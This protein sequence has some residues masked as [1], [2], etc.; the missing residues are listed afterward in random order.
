MKMRFSK[1]DLIPIVAVAA[2]AVALF[3][4]FLPSDAPAARV[5][6]YQKGNLLTTLPLDKDTTYTVTGAYTNIV[7]VKDGKVAVTQSNCPGSDC[8]ACGWASSSGKAIVCLPNGLEVRVVADSD[9]DIV[10]R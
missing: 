8:I 5:E 2:L 3:L 6:I 7:T 10:V 9:V 1:W 4:L